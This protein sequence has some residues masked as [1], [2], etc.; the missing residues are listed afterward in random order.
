MIYYKTELQN[1]FK[2]LFELLTKKQCQKL[3]KKGSKHKEY[4]SIIQH[5]NQKLKEETLC[6]KDL[7]TYQDLYKLPSDTFLINL[8]IASETAAKLFIHYLQ[9]IITP[10]RSLGICMGEFYITGTQYINDMSELIQELNIN[11][12]V[13]VVSEPKNPYDHKAVKVLTKDN[14]KL[15]YIPKSLNN[16]PSYMLEND[17]KL[18]GLIKRAQW[19]E[20]NFS[21]KVMLYIVHMS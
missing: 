9:E 16:F 12:Q 5:F 13:Q 11:D 14:V 6:I 10:D 18:F 21:I 17:E 4:P 7:K 2:V 15:G 19:R 1:E 20:E 8:D 3:I